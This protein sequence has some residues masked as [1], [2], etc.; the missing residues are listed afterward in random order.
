MFSQPWSRAMTATPLYPPDVAVPGLETLIGRVEALRR[1]CRQRE[2][3]QPETLP[4]TAEGREIAPG[5]YL[6]ERRYPAWYLKRQSAHVKGQPDSA[7][8]P[9]SSE[10]DTLNLLA[11]CPVLL[12]DG[13]SRLFL[14]GV[15]RMDDGQFLLRQAYVASPGAE[16]ALLQWLEQ[17]LA[18]AGAVLGASYSKNLLMEALRRQGRQLLQP[19]TW[20]SL[21]RR[22]KPTI[23][24]GWR[25]LR[26]CADAGTQL[27]S[28]NRNLLLA[29]LRM[30]A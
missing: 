6:S 8:L 25:Q 21:R 2:A 30:Y 5:L 7:A 12:D 9:L 1:S 17:E 11:L 13:S 14:A 26:T 10:S 20:I 28:A 4:F 18:Q 29:S 16:P 23:P 15:G 3:C 22:A 24:V 19:W 27:L